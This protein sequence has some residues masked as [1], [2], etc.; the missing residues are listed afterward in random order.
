MVL[1]KTF[2]NWFVGFI[3]GEGCFSISISIR[4]E[5]LKN[6]VWAG[7]YPRFIFALALVED[8]KEILFDI[9]KRLGLGRIN[10]KDRKNFIGNARNQY[11]FVI[12][13]L[14]EC[15]KLISYI[16]CIKW[17]TKK[18]KDFLLWKKG[19]SDFSKKVDL[20]KKQTERIIDGK[21]LRKLCVLR[22]SMNNKN[23][24]KHYKTPEELFRIYNSQTSSNENF[25]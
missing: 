12:D 4:K 22:E 14:K 11:V 24:P 25:K 5:K 9:K 10:F 13:S 6:H 21:L 18:Y 23:K 20:T 19:V 8:D 2:L 1:D 15:K 7:I 16:S 17:R 3:E